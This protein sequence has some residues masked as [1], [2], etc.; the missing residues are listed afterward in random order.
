MIASTTHPNDHQPDANVRIRL[1]DKW[2]TVQ[3]ALS[4]VPEGVL[5]PGD[6]AV[7]VYMASSI[8]SET[9]LCIR[10]YN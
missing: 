2:V 1:L 3:R 7:L 4:L 8:D 5:K 10:Y 6:I 9:G